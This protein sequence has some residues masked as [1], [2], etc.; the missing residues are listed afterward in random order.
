M[1]KSFDIKPNLDLMNGL[2]LALLAVI[3]R[4]NGRRI[5]ITPFGVN[6]S[7]AFIDRQS[8]PQNRIY[9]CEL[10]ILINIFK[11]NYFSDNNRKA[12]TNKSRPSKSSTLLRKICLISLRNQWIFQK[13]LDFT[14][15]W[16]KNVSKYSKRFFY[17]WELDIE[18]NV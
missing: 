3:D 9:I 12:I 15:I 16:F 11:N 2:M 17:V 4:G 5:C 10:I 18:I 6:I 13:I 1:A 7:L 8:Y 14:E